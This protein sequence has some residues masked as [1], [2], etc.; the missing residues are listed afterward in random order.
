MRA[1]VRV[2]PW[3]ALPPACPPACVMLGLAMCYTSRCHSDA[4]AGGVP[5]SLRGPPLASFD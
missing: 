3:F 4:A 5:S 2:G 1:T